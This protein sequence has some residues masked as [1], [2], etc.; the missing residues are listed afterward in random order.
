MESDK[1]ARQ[2][3]NATVFLAW[4]AGIFTVLSLIGGIYAEVQLHTL[5][6]PPASAS[7]SSC[8]SQGGSDPTC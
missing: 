1:Y 8:M 7:S 4:L 2:T 3:R 5:T 6:S